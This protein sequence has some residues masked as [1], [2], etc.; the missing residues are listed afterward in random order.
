MQGAAG[1]HA[2]LLSIH[3]TQVVAEMLCWISN[4]KWTDLLIQLKTCK[5]AEP[6]II[7]L[8]FHHET[9]LLQGK[10]GP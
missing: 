5:G 2:S 6:V 7:E 4:G 1:K 10:S 8:E 9:L 3:V